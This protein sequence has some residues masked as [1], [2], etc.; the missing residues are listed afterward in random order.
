MSKDVVS[1]TPGGF[2]AGAK[3]F[4]AVAP[5]AGMGGRPSETKASGRSPPL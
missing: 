2:A 4:Q 1:F 5:K 3:K